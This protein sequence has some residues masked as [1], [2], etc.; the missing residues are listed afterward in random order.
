[1]KAYALESY[2][3][4]LTMEDVDKPAPGPGQVLVQVAAAGVNPLDNMIARGDFKQLLRYQLPQVMGNELAGTVVAVGPNVTSF[5]VGDEIY[6]RPRIDAIGAFAEY[7]TIDVADV[8]HKPRTISMTEAA[9]LPLVMLT[10]IQAFTEKSQVGPGTKVFIQ[11]GTGGLGSVAIQVAK[12]LGAH[13]ATTVSTPN[14]STAASL[15]A[16]VIVDYR[17]QTYEEIISDYDVVLDTLGGPETIRAMKILRPGGTLVSVAGAP[18]KTIAAEL[19]KPWLAPVFQ[20]L[21]RKERKAA[22]DLDITYVFLFMRASGAQ[23]AEYH[24][25]VEVG[26]ISPLIGQ[27]FTFDRLPEALELV[28]S[29]GGKPGKTMVMVGNAPG[30]K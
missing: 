23:L 19:G 28:E 9:A 2:G 30:S 4:A 21:S 16:D 5:A 13:V 29:G 24:E 26:K 12:L 10:A 25:A 8:A 20:L 18:E 17:T 6:A 3:T 14:V 22:R 27:T 1:M 15:G 7:L 11:G